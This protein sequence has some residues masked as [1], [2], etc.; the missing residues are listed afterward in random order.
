MLVCRLRHLS[1]IKTRLA[2]QFVLA[3]QSYISPCWK[4]KVISQQTRDVE[5][6]LGLYWA[7]VVDDR[8]TIYNIFSHIPTLEKQPQ[9]PECSQLFMIN[10]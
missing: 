1:N 6:M 8:P 3:R 5:P 4:Q 2:Q 7:D 9:K 10:Y